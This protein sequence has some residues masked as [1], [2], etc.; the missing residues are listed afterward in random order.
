MEEITNDTPAQTLEIDQ[1]VSENYLDYITRQSD[2]QSNS[3]D[4]VSLLLDTFMEQVLDWGQ[5][6]ALAAQE[7]SKSHNSIFGILKK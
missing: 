7:F 1:R 3:V 6:S 4:G 5:I 2:E